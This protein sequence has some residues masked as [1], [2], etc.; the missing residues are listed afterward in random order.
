[1]TIASPD[2]D[3]FVWVV[4]HRA[5]P[6]DWLFVTLSV[7]G[8]AGLMWIGLAVLLAWRCGRP[9]LVTTALTAGAVWAADLLTLTIKASVERTRPYAVV[10]EADPLLRADVGQSFPSGHAATSFAGAVMLAYLVRRYVPAL[11]ALAALTAYSRVY[12]GVHYPLDVVVGAALGTLVALTVIAA[13]R[14]RLR[15]RRRTS[16]APPRRRA[17]PPA[18]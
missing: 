3:L 1:M 6:L 10:P 4:E 2:R 14:L 9:V 11:F 5:E 16:E 12:V 13:L 15:L 8:Y 17:T 18:G 7:L